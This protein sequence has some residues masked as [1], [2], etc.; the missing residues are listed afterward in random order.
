MMHEFVLYPYSDNF[1]D[2]HILK[3]SKCHLIG[4]TVPV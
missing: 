2:N 4:T 1:A 3:K